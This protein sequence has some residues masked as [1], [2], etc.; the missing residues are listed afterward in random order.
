M[1]Q[2]ISEKAV[3]A[4]VS[5]VVSAVIGALVAYIATKQS[6]KKARVAEIEKRQEALE[7]GTKA[8]L[9]AEIIRN[10]DKYTERGWVPLYAREALDKCYSAYSGLNGNGA[11][12]DLYEAVCRLPNRHEDSGA[13]L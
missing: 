2:L 9:R 10:Y 1:A 6:D 5:A 13:D 3:T 8:L 12:R 4:L 7:N 11:M